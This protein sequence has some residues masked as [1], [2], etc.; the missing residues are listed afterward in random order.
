MCVENLRALL[1]KIKILF[2]DVDGTL[3]DGKLYY[4]NNGEEIKSFHT[5]DGLGIVAWQKLGGKVAVISGRKA[6]SVLYRCK[7]LGIPEI[8]LG[9]SNKA[10]VAKDLI[11]RLNIQPC[12]CACI[13]DDLNDLPLFELCAI[14]F[15]PANADTILLDRANIRLTRNGGEGCVREAINMILDS[16]NL[17][18]RMLE[19][20]KK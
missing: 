14:S 7:E 15:T 6:E 4:G 2:L 11:T 16:Q 17:Q 9:I 18:G 5:Q 1:A 8:H 19:Y 20:F 10:E 12:E 13:G 3:T